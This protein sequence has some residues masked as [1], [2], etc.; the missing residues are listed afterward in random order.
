MA[1]KVIM[2]WESVYGIVSSQERRLCC[3]SEQTLPLASSIAE[4]SKRQF[5]EARKNSP[6]QDGG[7]RLRQKHEELVSRKHAREERS[8]VKL[9]EGLSLSR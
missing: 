8:V 4:K 1:A 7:K 2:I 5:R 9:A 6:C 3:E